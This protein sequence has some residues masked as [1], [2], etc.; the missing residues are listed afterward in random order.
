[1]SKTSFVEINKIDV[2]EHVE[3]KMNLSYLSWAWAHQEMKKIDEIAEIKIHEFPDTD[4]LIELASKGVAITP[5]LAESITANYKK[6]KAGA[7][8][9]VSVTLNGRT[10]TEYLPVM[11]FKNKSMVNPTSMDVNK[12]HK[13]CFVKAL[14]LHGLGLYIYA[15]EDLPEKEPPKKIS[16]T[17]AKS[18]T[19]LIKSVAKEADKTE[20]QMRALIFKKQNLKGKVEDLTEDDYGLILNY[21]REL[22]D[23]YEKQKKE[24]VKDEPKEQES[25]FEGSTTKPKV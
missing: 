19:T 7:Y 1:M 9:K 12:A 3:Q 18:L 8:V 23:Y 17:Q 20:A 11:D 15:G 16:D 2:S 6:D 5:E 4:A 21:V 22:K 25:L 10:E 13:R 14:A 24:Q